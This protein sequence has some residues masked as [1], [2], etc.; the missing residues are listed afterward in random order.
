MAKE[1][2][3]VISSSDDSN[4]KN[5]KKAKRKSKLDPLYV[6]VKGELTKVYRDTDGYF[7]FR[8][9]KEL[10]D[11]T[12]IYAKNFGIRGFKIPIDADDIA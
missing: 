6:K 3:L 12:I 7:I 1:K 9:S 4:E 5:K 10:K 8:A 2:D 11:G